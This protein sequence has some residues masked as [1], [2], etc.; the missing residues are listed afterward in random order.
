M[1]VR[2]GNPKRQT[3]AERFMMNLVGRAGVE[4]AM[5][6]TCL[7]YSQMSSPTGRIYPYQLEQHKRLELS[8]PVWKTGMLTIEHQCCKWRYRVKNF[9]EE[10]T[11]K[12]F[13][14]EIHYDINCFLKQFFSCSLYYYYSTKTLKSQDVLSLKTLKYTVF[15]VF[16]AFLFVL[17]FKYVRCKKH[18]AF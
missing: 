9:L 10:L 11:S 3:D 8:P 6:L 1:E 4:P 15:L 18:F 13:L 12:Q 17:H 2:L 5:F 16:L 14:M 7:I